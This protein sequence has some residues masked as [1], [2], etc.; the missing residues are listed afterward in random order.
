MASQV[1]AERIRT[2]RHGKEL[3]DKKKVE[4]TFGQ[5]WKRYDQWLDTGKKHVYDDR[6]R[7]KNHLKPRFASKALSQITTHDLEKFKDALLRKGLAPQT[8]KH[9]LV[10]VR[11]IYNKMIMWGLWTGQNPIKG[12]K[13]PKINNKR[14]RFLSHQEADKL[15][16]KIQKTSQQVWEY[17]LLSL[18]TGMRADECFSL[19]WG[20]IDYD[21]GMIHVADP[22]GG[23]PRD[24]YLTQKVRE[25]LQTKKEGGKADLVFKARHGGKIPEVSKTVLR[26][27]NDL[28]LNEGITDRRQ[29]ASFHT[30]RHTFASWLAIQGTPILEIKE[31]LGHATLAMTE[32]YAHLIPDQKRVSIARMEA[33]FLQST[34]LQEKKDSQSSEPDGSH[35][36]PPKPE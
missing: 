8:T 31:L 1:R 18:H 21:Q 23:P 11:Q 15:L 24:V 6:N 2:L 10:I 30:L 29:K 20:H 16:T 33:A 26:T 17:S 36:K 7:Y 22:K 4:L 34:N 28:K 27:I 14:V 35:T 12:V 3:P 19:L 9:V 25:M 32:R 13:M 5:A